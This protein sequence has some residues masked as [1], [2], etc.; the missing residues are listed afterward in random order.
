MKEIN[1]KTMNQ[2]ERED[3]VNEVRVLASIRH[4]NIIGYFDAFFEKDK[5]YIITEYA[6]FGDLHDKLKRRKQKRKTLSED[7]IW[8]YFIQIVEGTKALHS[9]G[10]LHRDLKSPNIFLSS[11]A[12]VKLGDLGVAKQLRVGEKF[13]R[14]QI[15]T[16]YYISPEIWKKQSYNAKSD[17]WSIGCLLYE[18]ATLNHPFDGNDQ[19][20]LARNVCKGTYPAIS[21]S[22]SESMSAMIKKLLQVDPYKRPTCEEILQ[23]PI[24]SSRMHLL[25]SISDCSE[26]ESVIFE[27]LKTIKVPRRLN[28]LHQFLPATRYGDD[29]SNSS[30]Q[31]MMNQ[32]SPAKLPSSSRLPRIDNANG[33]AAAPRLAPPHAAAAQPVLSARQPSHRGGSEYNG[34]N[35][36][37]ENN[38]NNNNYY[39]NNRY[40]GAQDDFA[41]KQQQKQG[42]G[43]SAANWDNHRQEAVKQ[44][45]Q[46]RGGKRINAY[47]SQN[48]P[49]HHHNPITGNVGGGNGNGGGY[50]YGVAAN[51]GRARAYHVQR[52]GHL[53]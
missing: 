27:R 49:P 51:H 31:M 52:A 4:P 11:E 33:K 36:G 25:S 40:G 12:K 28:D 23:D 24:I 26:N 47:P 45:A 19:N 8:T 21:S 14:T 48:Y 30:Q 1:I 7:A 29:E 22:Y 34:G 39:H 41:L 44:M 6:K 53:F 16:P 37:K 15:G 38:N 32:T 35:G 9:N 18:M 50:A 5:L 20:Q 17:V 13:T 46:V 10:V 42:V 3:A 43:A 2:K